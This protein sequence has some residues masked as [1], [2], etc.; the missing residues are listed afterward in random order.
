[1]GNQAWRSGTTATFRPLD[2][3]AAQALVSY[4]ASKRNIGKI[5]TLGGIDY[6]LDY[7]SRTS[8]AFWQSRGLSIYY[9][10]DN[11]I[12]RI[13]DHWAESNG[14]PGSR[15]LNC[16]LIGSNLWRINNEPNDFIETKRFGAGRFPF[17]LLAG[18]CHQN[19]FM[20]GPSFADAN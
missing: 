9:Q 5:L 11:Q 18:I 2:C 19:D 13:S 3:V 1:M 17:R 12:I 6:H 20:R 14:H 10:A 4:A 8:E 15:K 16:G 7:V